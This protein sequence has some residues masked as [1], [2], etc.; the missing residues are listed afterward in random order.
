MWWRKQPVSVIK[1]RK[2]LDSN[3]LSTWKL[4]LKMLERKHLKTLSSMKTM[5]IVQHANRD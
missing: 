3:K 2:K 1:I 4:D 5:T